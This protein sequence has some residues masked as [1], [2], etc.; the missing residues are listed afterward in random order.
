MHT[1]TEQQGARIQKKIFLRASRSRVWHAIAE[2]KEFGSWFG[3]KIDG[4]FSPGSKVAATIA[5]T[6]VDADIAKQQAAYAGMP[7]EMTIDRIDPER[8]FAFR[9]HPFATEPSAD[10]SAEPMTL[11]SF[12]IE[13]VPDG[14]MMTLTE[15]GFDRLPASR[16]AKAFEANEQGWTHQM[17][18]I[19]KYLARR[20]P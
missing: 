3:L 12:D 2:P 9:W 20:N 14:A 17:K 6:T 16:R 18:L 11:V 19:E 1:E 10:Y 15:S 8:H 4:H 7:L 13:E 5:P